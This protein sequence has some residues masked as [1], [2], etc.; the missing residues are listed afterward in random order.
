MCNCEKSKF[1]KEQEAWGL[2]RKLRG[3]KIPI[4]YLPI[5]II[6]F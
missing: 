1:I 2:L 3:I 5:A 6:L 4:S